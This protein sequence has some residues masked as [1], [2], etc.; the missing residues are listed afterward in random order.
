MAQVKM[1]SPAMAALRELSLSVSPVA[2]ARTV[3][4]AQDSLTSAMFRLLCAVLIPALCSCA[5]LHQRPDG[6]S[7]L[8]GDPGAVDREEYGELEYLEEHP[9]DPMTA[10]P[11]ELRSIPGFPERLVERLIAERERHRTIRRLLEALTP[12]ERE[13][14]RRYESYL[15]LPGRLPL[16]LEAWY[17]VDRLGPENERRD[18]SRLTCRSDRFRLSARYRS[19]EIYRLYLAGSWP[20]GHVRLHCG[21][22]MPDLAMG[23]CFSSYISSYP[24]S[25]GYHIRKRRWVSGATSLYGVSMRGGAAEFWTGPAR[26]LLLGGRQCSYSDGRL[27]VEGPT[28]LCG[29][30]ALLRNGFSAGT[31]LHAVDGQRRDPVCSVDLSWSG[32]R[33]DAAAEIASDGEGWSGIWAFSVRGE[34]SGMSILLYDIPPGR[35]HPMGRSFYGAG[36]WR[37]GCSLVLDQRLARRIRIFSAFERSGANDPYEA[38]RRDLLR[39]ECRWSSGGNSMKLSLK[40]RIERRSILMPY[41]SGEEQPEDEVT[42]SI[43]LLQTWRLP[44]SLRLRISCRAPLE[45]GRSG[46]LVCP[47]LTIDRRFS[48]TLSWALH[49]AIEGSP[50]FYCY[51]RSPRGLYPWRALRGD[52]WRVA[53]IGVVS[54]GPAR[55]ALGLAVQNGGQY[56]GAA[57]AGLAF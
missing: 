48:A 2:I 42:D 29:R 49:R 44:A 26:I 28:V 8:D 47:S 30:L 45:R 35:D 24:F 14:L 55:L 39:F 52:G 46:F 1:K 33:I 7:M 15:E 11:R 5:D 9:L 23:L 32:E 57:Q 50:L 3:R 20:T 38:R 36:R 40:R 43:H 17:T 22:L 37:R 19:E 54:V 53:L 16:H 18:D 41:P 12:P 25:R 6:S 4:A 10:E 27:D 56:E 51:E 13:E 34:R 21:D 31:T